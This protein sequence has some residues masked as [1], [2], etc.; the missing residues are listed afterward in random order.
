[1]GR[2]GASVGLISPSNTT[3]LLVRPE[4]D[5]LLFSRGNLVKSMPFS[6]VLAA[7]FTFVEFP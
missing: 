5:R 7:T 4:G 3:T 2:L 1:M 6:P